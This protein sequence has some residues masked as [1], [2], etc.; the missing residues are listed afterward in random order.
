MGEVWLGGEGGGLCEEEGV[1]WR[2]WEGAGRGGA[3]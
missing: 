2:V 1:E 3:H